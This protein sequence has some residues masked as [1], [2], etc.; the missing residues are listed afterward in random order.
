MPPA[1]ALKVSA[2]DTSAGKGWHSF[3][4][5]AERQLPQGAPV[6]AQRRRHCPPH[7][8]GD[9]GMVERP[10]GGAGQAPS[11]DGAQ[12]AA[13]SGRGVQRQL[14]Y[15]AHQHM[16]MSSVQNLHPA[17]PGSG[18]L[19]PSRRRPQPQR[20]PHTRHTRRRCGRPH[21]ATLPAP[22]GRGSETCAPTHTSRAPPSS[23]LH[24]E[25]GNAAKR[26]DTP[27]R[28]RQRTVHGRPPGA[29]STANLSRLRRRRT[30]NAASEVG[31]IAASRRGAQKKGPR[32]RQRN[33]PPR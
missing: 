13:Q 2:T 18:G 24:H 8:S 16:P 9:V 28:A 1:G 17:A 5:A 29:A 7:P 22:G 19:P 4:N 11:S 20:R 12:N 26:V 23:F 31:P 25:M 15:L 27:N 10:Q 6:V 3:R 30:D 21:A 32:D 33:T 14:P